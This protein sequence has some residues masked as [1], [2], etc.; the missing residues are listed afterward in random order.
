MLKNTE[1]SISE[2]EKMLKDERRQ[3]EVQQEIERRKK[4]QDDRRKRE[5]A[6]RKR[7]APL[8]EGYHSPYRPRRS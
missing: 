1:D 3:K 2:I 8:S 4:E 5:D 6:Q 7:A